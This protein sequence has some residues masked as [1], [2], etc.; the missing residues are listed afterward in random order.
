[1]KLDVDSYLESE[2]ERDYDERSRDLDAEQE[3]RACRAD[4]ELDH[5]RAM[6]IE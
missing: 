2:M 6:E 4:D 5:E 3:A 1:M